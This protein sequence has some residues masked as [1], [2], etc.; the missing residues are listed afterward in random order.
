MVD[1]E[2]SLSIA[3]DENTLETYLEERN[4]S[5]KQAREIYSTLLGKTT[6][7]LFKT[8][9]SANKESFLII[10]LEKIL[11]NT[12]TLLDQNKK[13]S[14][15]IHIVEEDIIQLKNEGLDPIILAGNKITT[16]L[17]LFEQG[18]QN[19][20]LKFDKF[21]ETFTTWDIGF[22]NF[23]NSLSSVSNFLKD[24]SEYWKD[25]TNTFQENLNKIEKHI[26]QW[27]DEIIEVNNNIDK[28]QK[29]FIDFQQRQAQLAI[30]RNIIQTTR[31]TT[32]SKETYH[33]LPS[34]NHQWKL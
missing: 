27:N 17:K 25:K 10:L 3:N 6:N 29:R 19:W 21:Q 14:E 18:F 15:K 24:F 5:Y 28:I 7:P 23:E 1:T 8:G 34:H 4:P 13:L 9:L 22:K 20:N 2:L 12:E 11:R 26:T 32:S 30:P 16:E 33:T 31:T